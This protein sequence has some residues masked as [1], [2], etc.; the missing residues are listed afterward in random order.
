[1]QTSDIRVNVRLS[2]ADAK[3]FQSLLEQSGESAS[4]VVRQALHAYG[5]RRLSPA[6]D[7]AQ[8]LVGFIAA[9]EGPED[10]SVQYKHYLADSLAHKLNCGVQDNHDSGR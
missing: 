1:M 7:P 2:G 4:N 3:N 8:L 6:S 9:G 5:A 10:L